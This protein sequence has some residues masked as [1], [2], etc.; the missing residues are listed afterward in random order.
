MNPTAREKVAQHVTDQVFINLE[1]TVVFTVSDV[2]FVITNTV[3]P[4]LLFFSSLRT[5]GK[6][7]FWNPCFKIDCRDVYI[8][9]Y[10]Y[11]FS[12]YAG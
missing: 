6:W 9:T 7:V 10:I 5:I 4:F 11:E 12:C 8:Y 2:T 1:L 3:I